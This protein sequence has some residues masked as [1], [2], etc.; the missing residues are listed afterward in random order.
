MEIFMQASLENSFD[1]I[2]LHRSQIAQASEIAA[3][4]F[5]NDPVF[6]YLTPDDRE[7]RLQVLTWLTSKAIEYCTPYDRVYTT[8][9][10]QGIAAWLPPD[11]FPSNPF[12]ILQ[13]I[14]Q[15]E[16]YKLPFKCGWNRLG[17]WLSGLLAM[18]RAHQE[19][20]GDRSHWYL[21]LMIVNPASQ[22][23]G[24]GSRLLQP[25]LDR[26]SQDGFPCYLVTSTEKAVCFYRKNGF[27]IITDRKFSPN[28]PPFWTLKRN[29]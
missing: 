1:V 15:L 20:M 6:T 10:L 25:V 21:E 19:D 26:A 27:E 17:R 7:L 8:S 14:A 3:K 29:P 4:A 13:T 12:Q 5:A 23:R 18:E 24:V 28:S 2:Q 11:K 9:D 22:G 16:L